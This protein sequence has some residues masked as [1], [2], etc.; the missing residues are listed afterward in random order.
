MDFLKVNEVLQV[1]DI[2]ESMTAAE[3]GCG[4]ADFAMT[5]AKKMP[6][7]RVYA[8]DIQQ[9]KLSALK[10]KLALE[11]LTN[12]VA[13][14][15]DLEAPEGSTLKSASQDIVL[16]PN[17]LFQTENRY[18]ILEEAKR[19]LISG[20]QLLVVDWLGQAPF[21]PKESL[22]NPEEIKQMA[23]KLG[24]SLKKEFAAGDYHYALLFI[25]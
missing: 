4:S 14:L 17:M 24:L 18:G 15:C 16:I 3:F 8:L 11:K 12:V 25:K 2:K 6:V 20:G 19:I 5:L 9:E 13:V 23:V 22:A 21:G 7:G 1:L 10:S